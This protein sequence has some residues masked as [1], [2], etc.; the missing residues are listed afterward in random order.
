MV[1][2]PAPPLPE[3]FGQLR[4]TRGL[5]FICRHCNRPYAISRDTALREW[6]RRG[7]IAQAAAETRCAT[8]RRRGM[9]V[10]YAPFKAALGSRGDLDR[11]VEELR[12]L[13]PRRTIS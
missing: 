4:R 1:T 3:R 7:K 11:L 8:C 12:A 6:G 10:E 9:H 5:V 2:A 13:T